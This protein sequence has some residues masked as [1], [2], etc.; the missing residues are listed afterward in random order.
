MNIPVRDEWS[1][2]PLLEK[3]Y[4]NTLS[5]NDLISPLYGHRYL[6]PR[7]ILIYL[8]KLNSGNIPIGLGIHILLAAGIFTILTYQIKKSVSGIKV[9]SLIF[10][11]TISLIIFSFSQY[12]PWVEGFQI[13]I[14][15]SNFAAIA[16]FNLLTMENFRPRNF[17]IGLILGIISM[18][19]F[20]TGII[21][22]FAGFILLPFIK[23]KNKKSQVLIYL[24]WSL[25]AAFFIYLY[26]NGLDSG[27]NPQ[28]NNL[29]LLYILKT[30]IFN[31]LILFKFIFILLGE[32]LLVTRNFLYPLLFGLTGLL[33]YLALLF[34]LIYFKKFNVKFLIFWIVLS[35]FTFLSTIL[36]A[37]GRVIAGFEQS[38]AP[39]YRTITNIF[40]ICFLLVSTTSSL[41]GNFR[42]RNHLLNKYL[43]ALIFI[44]IS[45]FFVFSDITFYSFYPRHFG[46][47]TMVKKSLLKGDLTEAKNIS[48]DNP[49]LFKKNLMV[50]KKYKLFLFNK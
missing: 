12:L 5:F 21:Y 25:S 10:L 49:E 47:L 38:L 16:G 30:V 42:I 46:Y 1:I 23:T 40:W 26:I 15:L 43:V 35:I 48:F 41:N 18:Y 17:V 28:D 4:N 33:I 13:N 44:I 11:P 45:A 9:N 29:P 34:H 7:I 32:A 37:F 19:S 3:S 6:F 2:V 14:F 36:I 50:L 22:W 20:S 39:Q 31:P 27:P 8:A 24:I